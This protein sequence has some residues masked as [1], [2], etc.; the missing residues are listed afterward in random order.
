MFLSYLGILYIQ[1]LIKKIHSDRV[2]IFF[3]VCGTKRE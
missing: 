1:M 2:S 3:F